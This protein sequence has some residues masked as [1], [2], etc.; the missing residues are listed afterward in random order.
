MEYT[1]VIRTLGKAGEKYQTL[2]NSLVSQTIPPKEIIVY[3]AEGYPIPTET[4]GRERYVYVKKGMVAQ[5]A[6]RYD[7]VDTEFMLC[8]DDDLFLPADFVQTMYDELRENEGN[9]ISPDIFPNHERGWGQE[10]LMLLSGRMMARRFPDSWGYK[11]LRTGGYSYRKNIDKKVYPSQTNAGACFFCRKE[12]FLKVSF[13][14]EM[15]LD[16]TRYPIGEDQVMY[17]KM[18]LSGLKVLISYNSGI[19]HL[20][21]GGNMTK[22]KEK[23]LIYSDFR[24]KTIFWHRFI[25]RPEKNLLLKAWDCICIGYA[26]TFAFMVSLLK[27]RFDILAIKYNSIRDAARFLRSDEYK[28][29][30]AIK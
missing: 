15:W 9:V 13:E 26:F 2:L 28:R 14:D 6:L 16:S 29:L 22:E 12:D 27:L 3:I 11:V 19:K 1:A 30:P 21:A 5:R 24:F 20:D 10:I 7:E 18:F 23:M 25:F 8:L 4:V 17:Y